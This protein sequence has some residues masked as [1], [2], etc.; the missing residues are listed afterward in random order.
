MI[1]SIL[2]SSFYI[3]NMEPTMSWITVGLYDTLWRIFSRCFNYTNCSHFPSPTCLLS[4]A[5]IDY[6]SWVSAYCQ[7][8]FLTRAQKEI[9]SHEHS[10][11]SI[12]RDSRK[13]GT[14]KICENL[15]FKNNSQIRTREQ[16]RRNMQKGRD[17]NRT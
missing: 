5:H 17:N 8:N 3:F 1:I 6:C 9:H 16:R 15:F 12:L 10:E 7:Q 2:I 11:F 4:L 14:G 13:P